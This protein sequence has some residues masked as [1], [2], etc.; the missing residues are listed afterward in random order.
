MYSDLLQAMYSDLLQALYSDPLQA[1]YS[2]LLQAM[3][4]DLRQTYKREPFI[5]LG[6][7]RKGLFLHPQYPTMGVYQVNL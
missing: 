6:S 4:S 7:M 5:V 2:D 1:M 3:Y